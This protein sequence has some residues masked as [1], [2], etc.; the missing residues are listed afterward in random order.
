MSSEADAPEIN[1]NGVNIFFLSFIVASHQVRTVKQA[2]DMHGF[3][4]KTLKISPFTSDKKHL[5]NIDDNLNRHAHYTRNFDKYYQP[6]PLQEHSLSEDHVPP[7][8]SHTLAVQRHVIPTNLEFRIANRQNKEARAMHAKG[9]VLCRIGITN[10]AGIEAHLSFR[11]APSTRLHDH[12]RLRL[13]QAVRQW[14]HA[15]PPPILLTLPK[16]DTLLKAGRWTYTVYDP[17]LLLPSN[18]LAQGPWPELLAQRLCLYLPKLYTIIGQQLNV[19]HIAINGP[20]P[21]LLPGV[22]NREPSLN[23]LRSPSA[24]V[25]LLGDFGDPNLPPHMLNFENAFWVRAVQSHITQ[26]W[27]PLYT[28][29]SRGNISEKRRLLDVISS[30]STSDKGQIGQESRDMT[31]VDLYAGIGYFAFSYAKAGVQK[32]LCWELNGWSVEGL[33]RGAKTNG[34][35][36]R[37]VRSSPRGYPLES[38]DQASIENGKE[39]FLVFHESNA[40]AAN[41]VNALRERI[42]P[43]RHVNCG[44]LPTSCESWNIAIQVLDPTEGGWI[45]AHENVAAKDIQQRKSEVVNIFRDLIHHYRVQESAS[46][47]IVECQHIEKVKSYAP[48]VIHCVYDIVILPSRR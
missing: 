43:I 37:V 48:G 39:R 7:P 15:L 2:L 4:D 8:H 18:F 24:L 10:Q 36:T 44:Y 9:K 28:M 6:C 42:A 25:P 32:V 29:F 35:S 31:A 38:L 3:L 12:S 21:A 40:N 45:H 19:T 27:A 20:I 33:R 22:K 1:P 17:M 26:K 34:W 5:S 47:F 30:T 23:I 41:R 14:L 16:I 46:N 11:A 13:A